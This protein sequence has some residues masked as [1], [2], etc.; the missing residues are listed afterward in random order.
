MP[1]FA[2]PLAP[3]IGDWCEMRI[4]RLTQALNRLGQRIAQVFVLPAAKIMALHHDTAAEG[5][6][7]RIKVCELAAYLG[8]EQ[9]RGSGVSAL[10]ERCRDLIP[11]DRGHAIGRGLCLKLPPHRLASGRR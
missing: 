10:V 2:Q 11:T 8:A 9:R 6:F 7:A 4:D 3:A 1:R 5:V